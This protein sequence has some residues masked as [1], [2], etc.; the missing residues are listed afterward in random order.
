MVI[1]EVVSGTSFTS[2]TQLEYGTSYQWRVRAVAS[3]GTIESEWSELWQFTTRGTISPAL[4]EVD[5][6]E[7]NPILP[8]AEWTAVDGRIVTS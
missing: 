6:S 5:S 4:P 3:S 8:T 7:N 2:D 1:Y